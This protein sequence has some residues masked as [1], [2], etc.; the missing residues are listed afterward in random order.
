M[1]HPVLAR[2]DVEKRLQNFVLFTLKF[3]LTRHKCGGKFYRGVYHLE[4]LM[5]MVAYSDFSRET[6]LCPFVCAGI[7][8]G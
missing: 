3:I 2:L 7:V 4:E 6:V 5:R 1:H 8:P